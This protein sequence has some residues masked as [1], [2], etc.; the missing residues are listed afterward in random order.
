MITDDN[1]NCVGFVWDGAKR[2]LYADDFLVAEDAEA[3]L[4]AGY[5]GTNIGCG[6]DIVPNSF[7]SGLID[8]VRIYER[9]VKP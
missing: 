1:W 6:N 7:L 2:T 9:A 4:E 8:Y 3:A 5:R